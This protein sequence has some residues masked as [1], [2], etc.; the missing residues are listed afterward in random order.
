[1]LTPCYSEFESPV[2]HHG[3]TR[4]RLRRPHKPHRGRFESFCCHHRRVAQLEERHLDTVEA[5]GSIPCAPTITDRRRPTLMRAA[6]QDRYLLI[7]CVWVFLCPWCNGSAE[8][9][10]P[11]SQ[12]SIPCGHPIHGGVWKSGFSTVLWKHA[13][14]GSNPSSLTIQASSCA[15]RKLTQNPTG[16]YTTVGGSSNDKIR[17]SEAR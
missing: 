11:S 6:Q 2:D 5:H 16:G 8:G 4:W 17:A 10:V 14:G 12:G 9:C 13:S 7:G 1:M 3:S 15:L